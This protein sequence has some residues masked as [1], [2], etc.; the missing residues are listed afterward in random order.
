MCKWKVLSSQKLFW[1]K[2]KLHCCETK[3]WPSSFLEFPKNSSILWKCIGEIYVGVCFCLSC[4]V[5]SIDTTTEWILHV[6]G[7]AGFRRE[8]SRG[9]Q[10]R[11]QEFWREPSSVWKRW[12]HRKNQVDQ[13]Y[14]RVLAYVSHPPFSIVS[15][16]KS[17][18]SAIAFTFRA[19]E[20]VNSK[21][22]VL[23]A[24]WKKYPSP[25]HWA[26][27][28]QPWQKKTTWRRFLGVWAMSSCGWEV[29]SNCTVQKGRTGPNTDS[30]WNPGTSTRWRTTPWSF[31]T[32]VGRQPRLQR[33][34]TLQMR[35]ENSRGL[36]WLALLLYF[37]QRRHWHLRL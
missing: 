23:S 14:T 27:F 34:L 3:L 36:L 37:R 12:R 9:L 1:D 30:D 17:I 10:S 26:I 6:L 24:F 2:K 7:G 19:R 8:L 16:G 18:F 15:H 28:L 29:I 35:T 31:K 25:M 20:M 33:Y 13:V 32:Q 22:R 11:V 4:E 5:S 21:K